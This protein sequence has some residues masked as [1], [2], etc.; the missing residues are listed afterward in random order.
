MLAIHSLSA[1]G[2]QPVSVVKFTFIWTTERGGIVSRL[3]D[4]IVPEFHD[5]D[6]FHEKDFSSG[7]YLRLCW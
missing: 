7:Q 4:F 5:G 2:E 6:L 1:A 3:Q